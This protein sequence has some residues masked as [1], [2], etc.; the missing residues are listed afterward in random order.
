MRLTGRGFTFYE[1]NDPTKH[2]WKLKGEYFA[3]K[4]SQEGILKK[5]PGLKVQISIRNTF[6]VSYGY[7]IPNSKL[8]F[9]SS[10]IF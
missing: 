9:A 5:S 7:K 6:T 8:T 3:R 2:T 10:I 4:E 1:D